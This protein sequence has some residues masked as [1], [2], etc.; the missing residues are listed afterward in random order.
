MNKR[1]CKLGRNWLRALCVI[2]VCGAA[3]SCSD[4]YEL[5]DGI[6]SWLNSSIYDYL[7]TSGKYTNFVKLIDDLEY[8]EVL[9]KTGSK[10]L[11]VAD[12]DAF[13]TFYK[14]NDWGV[15]SYGD[16]TMAQKKLLLN[17]AMVNNAYLLEMMSSTEGPMEGLC[18]RRETAA[19]VT[20]SVPHF[21]AEQLPI[22]YNLSDKDYWARFRNPEKGGIR[23]ALD[24]SDPMMT[25]FLEAQLM[26]K[27]ITNEDFKYII[28]RERQSNDAYV[29]DCKVVEADIRCQNGYVNRLD[30]V[31]VTPQN[32]AEVLRTNGQTNI[33][34]HMVERF[35]APFYNESLTRRFQLLY[36]NDVDSVYEKRYFS[37]RSR[38]GALTNDAGTD[39]VNNPTGNAVTYSLNYDLGWNSYNADDKTAKEED[40]GVIFAPVDDRLYD[41]FF[42]ADGGGRF[43]I[44]AYAPDMVGMDISKTDYENIYRAID[45]I[46]LNVIQALIN[47][48]M[49]SNFCSSVPSK[50]ETITDDAQDPML[51]ET[52]LKYLKGVELASNGAVF[53]MDEV[54]TPAQYASVSAPAY[55]STDMR[56]FNWAI[57]RGRKDPLN[58]TLGNT[59]ANFYA[60]LLAMS[61]RFSFFVPQD[62]NFWYIDPVS[63]KTATNSGTILKGRAYLYTWDETKSVPKC[64]AYDYNYDLSTGKGEIG[65]LLAN[66][67]IDQKIYGD[68]LRDMLETHTIVHEDNSSVT[69]IDE[70]ATG[71]EC[72]KHFFLSKNGAPLY[73]ENS[74]SGDSES[75]RIGLKLQG[76]WQKQHDSYSTV[77]R[78]DDKTR[79]SNGNG[80]GM[81]YEID[82][83]LLPTIESVYSTMYNDDE[84]SEFFELCA[85]DVEVLKEIGITS[86]MEQNRYTIFVDNGGIPCF[87]KTTGDRAETATNVRFFNNYRYTVYVPTND[88]VKDAIAKG[89]PTWDYIREFLELNLEPEDRTEMTQE[90]LDVRNE[91]ALAM[92]TALVNFVKYH[93][94]D[95]SVFADT[96][97][98]Q[99]TT[100]ETATIN[101][102]TGVYC[103]VDVSSEGNG[104]LTVTDVTGKSCKITD[105]K[106]LLTRDYVISSNYIAASSFAV[107]HG[108]EGVLDYKKFANESNPRY[109]SDWTT[110]TAAKKYLSKYRIIE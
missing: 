41:Y 76:G 15:G 86:T 91:K 39:P 101:S 10:T 108:I 103:K 71:I 6:P 34:S 77:I 105:R 4:D 97:S 55:V 3:Y 69:G 106:N 9:D 24:A 35:S 92:V 1:L 109:D 83:P 50:F 60:Y 110:V 5:D 48:L 99:K 37:L 63:F 59:V 40:M 31:L 107:L 66:V 85:T 20:D 38:T 28:G 27:N 81:A 87:D 68:R 84:F 21:T 33:F 89:L 104:S 19:T 61:S 94:Q 75:R 72:D 102:E 79:E 29:Y 16:L 49:K 7:Q 100:Y 57:E 2:S 18:L 56:I 17:S 67:S 46:P 11:F 52:H 70:T 65:D 98:I 88:A 12:D 30:R 90:E 14:S 82:T 93:F 23:L 47:N 26:T 43:L 32:M 25:H 96:P 73:I 54:L 64:A 78:F 80:N 8:A 42:T 74:Y 62:N 95:N 44:E 36:G 51:D 45:Q 58:E 53:L 13:A 22:S